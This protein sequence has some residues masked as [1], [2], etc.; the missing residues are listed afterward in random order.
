MIELERMKVISLMSENPTIELSKDQCE[1]LLRGLRF[2][3]SAIML[4]PHE[5]SPEDTAQRKAQLA[6]IASLAEQLNGH[7]SFPVSANIS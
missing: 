4:E 5:P 7:K 6:Q 1:V 3:R 2:V